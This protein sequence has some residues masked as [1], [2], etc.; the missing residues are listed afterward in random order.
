MLI[1]TK[2]HA[3]NTAND[4]DQQFVKLEDKT[5]DFKVTFNTEVKT[6]YDKTFKIECT[7]GD[8]T[9]ETAEFAV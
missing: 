1:N 7:N 8:Q 3:Y 4:F 5:N 9:V 6:L 2:W